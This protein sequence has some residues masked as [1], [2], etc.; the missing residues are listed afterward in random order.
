MSKESYRSLFV[1]GPQGSGKTAVGLAIAMRFR[2]A[3][4]RTA[5]MKP[6][7]Q[8]PVTGGY[9][10]DIVLMSSLLGE[11]LV[12]QH[13]LV[14]GGP[15]YLDRYRPGG[16]I[17]DQAVTAEFEA[18][19]AKADVVIIEQAA[20]PA[21]GAAM[22]MDAASLARAWQSQVLLVSKA[23]ND[24]DFD[25]S[26]LY[27][28]YFQS[29][30]TK[31]LGIIYN[32]VPHRLQNKVNGV[33]RQLLERGSYRFLGAIPRRLEVAA[34]TVRE[35]VEVMGAEV[36]TGDERLD[37]VVEDVLVG[38]MTMESALTYLRRSANKALITGG[39][40]ADIALAALETSTAVLVLTGGLYPDVRVLSRAQEK[41][42]PVILVHYDTFTA[43][44]RI[45]AVSRKIRPGDEEAIAQARRDFDEKCD[46]AAIKAALGIGPKGA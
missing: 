29:Q 30:G 27:Y 7:G 18:L 19:A 17:D 43:I 21:T 39:D 44:E 10:E 28:R 40:R 35:I 25:H 14:Q 33:Y 16:R 15:N 37:N 6:L 9:D 32:N 2:D 1:V 8:A 41:G 13:C 34:P 42:V 26:I 11:E 23:D 31:M 5:Y 4:Y 20:H 38:A 3:G 22:D 36:L 45:H 46:Y 12:G 24:E